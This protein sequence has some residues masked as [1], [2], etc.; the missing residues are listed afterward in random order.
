MKK[1]KGPRPARDA[2]WMKLETDKEIFF[3]IVHAL[4][5]FYDLI[6]EPNSPDLRS[7]RRRMVRTEPDQTDVFLQKFGEY[8]YFIFAEIKSKGNSESDSWI[9]ID[10]IG[11]ERDQL[12]AQ[13]IKEHPAFEIHCLQDLFEESCVRVSGEEEAK[14]QNEKFQT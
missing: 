14:I 10:G 12:K 13:G 6:R 7:F 3:Q 8:E 4:N 5:R 2:D 1:K 9:H 11:M